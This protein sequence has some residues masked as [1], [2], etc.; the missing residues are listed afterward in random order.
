MENILR[1][2]LDLQGHLIRGPMTRAGK[3]RKPSTEARERALAS[4]K[5]EA[6]G[7][8]PWTATSPCIWQLCRAS[9]ASHLADQNQQTEQMAASPSSPAQ[10]PEHQGHHRATTVLSITPTYSLRVLPSTAFKAHPLLRCSPEE[11]LVPSRVES[12][13]TARAEWGKGE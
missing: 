12:L 13:R 6:N 4:G 3:G 5:S 1:Q 7:S 10:P 2:N 8:A 9:Q 11:R